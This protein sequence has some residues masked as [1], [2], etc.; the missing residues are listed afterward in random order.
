[1]RILHVSSALHPY[2]LGGIAVH[3]HDTCVD[4][5]KVGHEVTVYCT[6]PDITAKSNLPFTVV[7]FGLKCTFMR[8]NIC[9]N[10]LP[11]LFKNRYLFDVI[12]AHSHLF[13]STNLCAIVRR[14]G[15]SPLIITN[16]GLRSPAIPSFIQEFYLK[17]VGRWTFNSADKI[18]CYTQVMKQEMIELGVKE[19]K[20]VII[21]QGIDVDFFSPRLRTQHDDFRILWVGRLDPGKG[22]K[23]MLRAFEQFHPQHLDAKLYVAGDGVYMDKLKEYVSSKHMEDTILILGS[24]DYAS[25]PDLYSNSDVFCMTSS[26]EAGPKTI[27]EAMACGCPVISNGLEHLKDIVPNGGYIVPVKDTKQFV[28]Q[29]GYVY[30]NRGMSVKLGQSGN[31]YVNKNHSWKGL[32]QKT[33]DISQLTVDEMKR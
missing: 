26:A 30:D 14:F 11:K 33:L 16:H 9:I 13:F 20:I 8:N 27:F 17:T 28:E 32:V 25:L 3:V 19:E 12:H 24:V 23:Y 4:S 10:M 31:A 15:S 29:L 7:N 5:A 22:L 2:T 18:L 6:V 1:M 21:P